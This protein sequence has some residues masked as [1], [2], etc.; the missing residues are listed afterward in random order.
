MIEYAENGTDPVRTFTSTD[1]EGSGIDWDVTGLDADDFVIDARG[2]L[3]FTSPPNYEDPTDRDNNPSVDADSDGD[4]AND[5]ENGY[6]DRRYEIT[7]RATEQETSGDDPRALSTDTDVIVIVTNANE[8]MAASMNRRQPEV[9]TRIT[10]IWDDP[11]GLAV[12]PETSIRWYVSKVTDPLADEPGHWIAATGVGNTTATYTP[13]GDRVDGLDPAPADPECGYRDSALDEDKFLRV[14]VSYDDVLGPGREIIA[15][16]EFAVRAEVTSDSD[17]GIEN[18]SNGSPGFR[19]KGEKGKYERTASEDIAVGMAVPG[20]A[21][22]ATDPQEED[23]DLLTYDL[24]VDLLD[25]EE[26]GP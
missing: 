14:V 19:G 22:T 15:V 24:D 3:M 23:Q 20:D 21:V 18:A 6:K 11:D 5:S 1:P 4:F 8:E 17:E 9:G 26:T 2:M 16:S 7:V 10:V 13:C 12:P 25:P